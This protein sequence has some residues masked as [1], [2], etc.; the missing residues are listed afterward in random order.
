ME[1]DFNQSLG[2]T[3]TFA[4]RTL[5][6]GFRSRPAESEGSNTVSVPLLDVSEPVRGLE[7]NT[8]EKALELRWSPPS[9]S[10]GG[11]PLQNLTGYRVYRSTTR[12]PGS[13]QRLGEADS[14]N[15]SERNFEFGR[16]YLFK[17]RAVFKAAGRTAESEDSEIVEITPRDTFPP[18]APTSLSAVYTTQAVELL[19]TANSEPELAGYNIYRREGAEQPRRIN[20]GLVRTPIFRDMALEGGHNYFYKVTAVDLAGNESPASAEIEVE[21]K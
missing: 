17:V 7:V 8:T 3:S 19:W 5:T 9:R 16:N 13:F 20:Q 11:R 2:T 1:Q 14:P 12:N 10:L 4:L 21:A 15:F 18:A 6:R